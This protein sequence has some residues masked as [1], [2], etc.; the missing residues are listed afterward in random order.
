MILDINYPNLTEHKE[1]PVLKMLAVIAGEDDISNPVKIHHGCHQIKHFSFDTLIEALENVEM[2]DQ[3]PSFE[4]MDLNSYGVVDN[5]GQFIERFWDPLENIEDRLFVISF[6]RIVRAEQPEEGGW[7]WHKWGPYIGDKN[8]QMEYI[9]DEPEI[10]E[11]Y[12]Y[13]VYEVKLVEGTI[14]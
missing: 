8:P 14:S 6:T 11:V 2:V 13:H 1:A 7:R 3:W 4:D 10:D 5:P 9:H 12:V